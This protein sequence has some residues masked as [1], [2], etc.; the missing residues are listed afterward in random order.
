VI[1]ELV[2]RLVIADN[3][4]LVAAETNAAVDN[5]LVGETG[6]GGVDED[7]LWYHHKNDRI[8]VARTNLD[9]EHVNPVAREKFG[10]TDPGIAEVVAS[11]HSSAATLSRSFDYVIVDEATQAPISSTLIS[12]I[13]GD[14]C[15][16]VGDHKQLPPFSHKRD[17]IRTSLFEHLYAEDG[18]Y[19]PDIGTQFD[20]QYRMREEIAEFPSEEF[21]DGNLKTGSGAGRLRREVDLEP[22]AIFD[23]LGP[24]EG[25]SV[26]KKNLPEAKYVAMQVK[27]LVDRKGLNTAQIG[28]A[29]AYRNQVEEIESSLEQISSPGTRAVKV[30]TFDSFQGSER[31][32]MILSFTRSNKNGNIGFLG[33]EIGRK[34]LNVAL[35][36]AKRYCALVGDWETLR[37]GSSLYER[38]YQY[39]DDLAPPKEIDPSKI[40]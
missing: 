8:D 11:T 3:T 27:M 1:I 13:K 37:E 24:N 25:G 34:R 20:I 21:Y 22:V 35:T 16:L 7:S 12:L 9:S 19:G 10:S 28:V 17:T 30:D 14:K 18:V 2:R 39:V 23:I 40:S 6:I 32:A 33:N 15:I 4:V 5:I 38:L 31:A 29:A 26:S 36:R